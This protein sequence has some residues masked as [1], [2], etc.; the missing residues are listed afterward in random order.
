MFVNTQGLGKYSHGC[1]KA[2]V[3]IEVF[4]LIDSDLGKLQG[5]LASNLRPRAA[6]QVLA[7]LG[8]DSVLKV[9][10]SVEDAVASYC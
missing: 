5:T 9:Y 7:L 2:A 6:M 3:H 10:D 4:Q 1:G 8:L